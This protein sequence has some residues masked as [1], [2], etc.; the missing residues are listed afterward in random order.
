ML[1]GKTFALFLLLIFFC[2]A[3]ERRMKRFFVNRP[4]SRFTFQLMDIILRF[5]VTFL[6]VGSN[7]TT[8]QLPHYLL[9]LKLAIFCKFN[10]FLFAARPIHSL[11]LLAP[12]F[13]SEIYAGCVGWSWSSTSA[14]F[15]E[16][17]QFYCNFIFT[18]GLYVSSYACT[19][20]HT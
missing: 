12:K 1:N 13:T 6:Q 9:K 5:H 14:S 11:L 10:D 8:A 15:F 20:S 7:G 19:L 18:Y 2:W 16:S 4:W 3:D 17:S